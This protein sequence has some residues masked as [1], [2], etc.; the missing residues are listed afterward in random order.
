MKLITIQEAV[1]IATDKLDIPATHQLIHSG[2]YRSTAPDQWPAYQIELEWNVEGAPP[3][4]ANELVSPTVR[5]AELDAIS[6]RI[7]A[8]Y[9]HDHRGYREME[10]EELDEAEYEAVYPAIPD[11]LAKLELP[12]Q[13]AE[14]KLVRKHTYGGELLEFSFRRE[15]AGIPVNGSQSLN[16]VMNRRRELIHLFWQWKECSFAPSTA[17]LPEEQLL[18]QLESGQLSLT[19]HHLL[20]PEHP[21]YIC[22]EDT[23]DAATGQLLHTDQAER[24]EI[25][26]LQEVRQRNLPRLEV[27]RKPIFAADHYDVLRLA[28]GMTEVDLSAP[29]PFRAELTQLEKERA[30]RIAAAY[31]SQLPEQKDCCYAFVSREGQKVVSG[32]QGDQIMVEVQRLIHQIPLS[33]GGIKLVLDHNTWKVNNVMDKSEWLGYLL[34]EKQ[35]PLGSLQKPVIA[36]EQA[37]E[38]LEGRLKLKLHYMMEDDNGPHHAREARLVYT[39]D[40][41]WLC[42]AVTGEIRIPE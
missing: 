20:S 25:I 15:Y 11:W 24:V 38:Q 29:H 9:R 39:L 28:D 13:P 23:F 32:M 37:W 21:V 41:D 35:S 8:Y 27:E 7:V 26:D 18:E 36:R 17:R 16:L 34:E 6:G 22:R 2:I 30:K 4:D 1:E 12:I 31:V 14:L 3:I 40:C 5:R 19:Y 10:R 42:N 33:G